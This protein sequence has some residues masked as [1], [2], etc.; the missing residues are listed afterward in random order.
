MIRIA[1]FTVLVFLSQ[2][3]Q[4][5]MA[6]DFEFSG[7][8][9]AKSRYVFGNAVVANEKPVIQGDIF[10]AHKKSCLHFDLWA[11]K[12]LRQKKGDEVDYTTGC[13]GSLGGIDFKADLAYYD[14]IG[15]RDDILT[16]IIELYPRQGWVIGGQHLRLTQTKATGKQL[17]VGYENPKWGTRII[18]TDF[19]GRVTV[20]KAWYN[21]P[22]GKDVTLS[23]TGFGVLSDPDKTGKENQVVLG[24]Q[25]NF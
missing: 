14:F 11:S 6:G 12:G 1:F 23:L 9:A 13:S 21:W 3:G 4:Q 15:S 10:V 8:I 19:F 24:I 20:L 5:A 16:P 7:F 17:Y 18:Y 22:I 25:Y 2:A